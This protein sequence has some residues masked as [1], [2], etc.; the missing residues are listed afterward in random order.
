MTGTTEQR[1]SRSIRSTITG[2]VINGLLAVGKITT[3]AIGHSQALIADGI[4]SLADIVSSIVV[5]RGVVV[6]AVPEDENHPYGHGKA[7]AVA[8]GVVGVLLVAAAI[9]IAVESVHQI[10]TPHQ[11]PR[12]YTLVVLVVVIVV[13]ELLFRRV[14]QTGSELENAAVKGDA[15]HHRSDAIT[16]FAAAIGIIV[17]LAGGPGYEWAD[18]AAALLASLFIAWN[19]VRIG[20]PAMDELMDAA[21]PKELRDHISALAAAVHGVEHIQKCVVRRHGYWFYVDLHVHVDP[22][23]T[24]TRSHAIAHEVKDKLRA[25][26]PRI[27]DVLIHIEPSRKAPEAGPPQ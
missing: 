18:D 10:V 2:M 17:A 15:W 11:T 9:W 4:E 1:L 12:A 20:R 21:A 6:A 13:K 23:M 5:W 16:S 8:A 14:L 3:G 24:V 27:R 22:Q 25:E 7:E 19:G 26:L